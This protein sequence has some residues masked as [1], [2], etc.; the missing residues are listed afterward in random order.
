[1][2]HNPRVLFL[3]EPTSAMDPQS[4]KQVRDAIQNLRGSGHTVI[5]CTHNLFEAETLADQIAVIRRGALIA[6]GTADQLKRELLGLPLW[7]VRLARPLGQAW[8]H[9]NGHL[10]VETMDEVSLRYRTAEPEAAN[11]ALLNCLHALDAEVLALSEMPR[12]LEDVYLK[13]IQ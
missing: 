1:M 12:S 3:D 9:L 13:L 4:A 5:L 8:P 7:Q 2:L 11:P 10:Q 6:R